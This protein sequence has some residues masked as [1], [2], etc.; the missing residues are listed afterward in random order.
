MLTAAATV[1]CMEDNSW[2]K[3]N[4]KLPDL[5]IF[6]I[7]FCKAFF[8]KQFVALHTHIMEYGNTTHFQHQNNKSVHSLTK[9]QSLLEQAESFNSC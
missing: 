2:H 7:Y 4:C 8:R 1:Y 6:V 3:I 5:Y 9:F